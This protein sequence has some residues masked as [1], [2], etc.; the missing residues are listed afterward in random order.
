M[1]SVDN[2]SEVMAKLQH[3][4]TE[5][6]IEINQKGVKTY[7]IDNHCNFI[8]YSNE[9]NPVRL[10]SGQRRIHTAERQNDKIVLSPNELRTLT[11][12]EELDAFAEVLQ[13]WPVVVEDVTRI[14][15]TEAADNIHEASTSI[16]ML[17]AEAIMKGDL[18]FFVDR[19]PSDAEAAADF[20]N[21]MNPIGLYKGLLN[22]CS[23]DADSSRMTVLTDE[24]LF[25]LFRT[26]IP[27]SRYFQDS[28][29]WRKRHYKTLGLGIDRQHRHPIDYT[30]RVRG[31]LTKW[32]VPNE[33]LLAPPQPVENV[34]PIKA[35]KR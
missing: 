11:S 13:R 31:V 27:D 29:T 21:R 7:Q 32:A 28:K 15:H 4:I 2:E 25:I 16:N 17:I 30:K 34:T 12:G 26:L 20:F 6:R 23:A 9:R 24:D 5:P 14:L 10:K 1:S 33:P 22:R 19:M 8:F 35:K 18:Q 3:W